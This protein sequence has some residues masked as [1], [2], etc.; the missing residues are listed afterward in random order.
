VSELPPEQQPPAEPVTAAEPSAGADHPVQVV[1]TDDLK[2]SRLTVFF[3]LLLVIPHLLW[4]TIWGIA[5]FLLAIVGWFAAL[6][7]GRLPEGFHRFQAKY[8]V[9][10]TRVYSYLY[11]LANPYPPFHGGPGDYPVDLQLP[12]APE[13]Q[14]RW[15]ILFRIILGIPALILAWVFSQ[16]LQILAFLGWFVCV[17]MGRMPKGMRDLGV[18]CL[19]YQEQ[20][21]CYML[22][23]TERYPSLSGP[24]P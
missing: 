3:R 17:V 5:A 1:V 2:R 6:F 20:T 4:L 13:R 15:K 14:S 12:M 21:N 24:T 23:L 18:Y 19:R 9:Y 8:Q 11:L 10:T 22:L 7:T 16:V